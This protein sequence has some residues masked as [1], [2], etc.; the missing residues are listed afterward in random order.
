MYMEIGSR[1]SIV[2]SDP[3]EFPDEN[4]G[5]IAFVAHIVAEANGNWVIRFARPVIYKGATWRFA[6][7]VTRL[8]GQ[9]DFSD[10]KSA[11]I[12]FITDEQSESET[13]RASFNSQSSV[14]TP[15]V[16]GSFQL[17]VY[18]PIREGE[19]SFTEPRWKAP[20]ATQ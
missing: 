20:E 1:V 19:D 14:S 17:G 15:W 3:W 5:R 8:V 16:I 2:V 18:E 6:I 12:L 10:D 7:P 11:N 4:E 9:A 13:F